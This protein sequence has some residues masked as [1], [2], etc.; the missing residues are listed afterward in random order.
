MSTERKGVEIL[1]GLFLLIGICFVGAM[2]VMFGRV[3][4]GIQHFYPL[5]V[6]FP[7]ANGIIAGSDVLLAGARIGH[8]ADA[9]ELVGNTFVVAVRLNISDGV[10]IPRQASFLVGSSGLLGDRFVEV[11]LA[12]K[13]DPADV[14]ASGERIAGTR[15]GGLDELTS[16]GG[17]VMDQLTTELQQIEVLTA[18]LNT[19]LLHERNLK[20]IESTFENLKAT[21][22]SFKNTARDLDAVVEKAGGAVDSV[23]GT[24]KTTDAAAA[25]LRLAIADIRKTADAATKAVNATGAF[26][27]KAGEGDGAL[28]ALINDKQM[29]DDLRTLVANLRRSGVLFYKNRPVPLAPTPVPTI[30]R[31]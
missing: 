11:R 10:K 25:D 31:R 29:A 20:N 3:G 9:P 1:V 28:G 15:A 7:N 22:E 18:R 27:K 26:V 19:G 6:E 16:K 2:V 24:V 30:R 21:T 8:V 14:F 4:Q 5:T 17:A 23:K 13:F 12:E